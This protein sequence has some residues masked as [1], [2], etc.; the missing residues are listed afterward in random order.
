MNNAGGGL[1][2]SGSVTSAYQQ[3]SSNST[4]YEIFGF[5]Q[6]IFPRACVLTLEG[7]HCKKPNMVKHFPGVEVSALPE[8]PNMRTLILKSAWNIMRSEQDFRTIMTALPHLREWN[9]SYA[10]PK[11]KSYHS[12]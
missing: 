9:T 5:V 8:L 12:K 6:M 4:L 2:F 3:A 11:S 1:E 10:K 7:G